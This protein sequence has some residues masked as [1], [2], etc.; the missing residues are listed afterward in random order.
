MIANC[1]LELSFLLSTNLYAGIE[2]FFFLDVQQE[3]AVPLTI[4]NSQMSRVYDEMKEL[5]SKSN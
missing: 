5:G 1:A 4:Q 3:V 2:V